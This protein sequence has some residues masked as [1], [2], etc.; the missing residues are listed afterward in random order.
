M[1]NTD[2]SAARSP[3]TPANIPRTSHL[4]KEETLFFVDSVFSVLRQNGWFGLGTAGFGSRTTIS[5]HFASKSRLNRNCRA[6]RARTSGSR[7]GLQ[8]YTSSLHALRKRHV[9][10]LP[11][12]M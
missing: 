4:K 11:S 1:Q 5:D 8:L 3:R 12:V 9:M 2:G 7:A 6:C 10:M